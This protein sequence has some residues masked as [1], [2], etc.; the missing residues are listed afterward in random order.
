MNSQKKVPFGTQL[1]ADL[2]AA[3]K[4]W[5]QSQAPSLNLSQATEALLRKALDQE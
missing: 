1:P 3:I 4:D 2:P 5:G